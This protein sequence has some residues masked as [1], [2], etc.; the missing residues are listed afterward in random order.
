V[1]LLMQSLE[2]NINSVTVDALPYKPGRSFI[3]HKQL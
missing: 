3:S 2:P 1:T